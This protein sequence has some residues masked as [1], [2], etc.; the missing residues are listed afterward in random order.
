VLGKGS[1]VRAWATTVWQHLNVAGGQ[2]FTMLAVELE[3]TV[4]DAQRATR[5]MLA[6]VS[7]TFSLG[8][9]LLPPKLEV[10]VRTGY[11]LCR[12]ADTVEDDVRM[13]AVRKAELLDQFVACF[14]D[15]A[16]AGEFSSCVG[17]L[18]GN[19]A[20]VD[21]V[22]ITQNVFLIWRQLD[23]DS[24]YITERW[25]T[26]MARGMRRFVLK[27]PGGIRIGTTP[28]LR[29]YC[30]FVAGT[31][32]HLLTELWRAHSVFIGKRA[33]ARLLSECEAFG[34]A[35]QLV[36]ILKD[37]A[38]DAE[39]ENAIYIP[40]ELLVARGSS[41]DTL[42]ADDHRAMNREA[43]MPLMAMAQDDILR[44]LSY[45]EALPNAAL[46]VRLF[47]VLPVL[48]AAAT[49]RELEQ[50]DAMLVPGGSVKIT[51]DEVHALVLAGSASMLTNLTLHRLVERVRQRPMSLTF[52]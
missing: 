29:E 50:T 33:Y 13:P 5:L 30:Y 51:R 23:A 24:R 47:C 35:L 28:E 46:R 6:R 17:E 12:I 31:V 4:V 18:T 26:E 11:L 14:G 9:R 21:L 48:L 10:A 8:I 40:A 16:T 43:L 49:M 19:Q 1:R 25:V 38:M 42:F 36:N 32:G 39:G 52:H 15:P 7:R 44:S 20:D 27:Y 45:I 37:I 2:S 22:A 3:P 41:H 34:E